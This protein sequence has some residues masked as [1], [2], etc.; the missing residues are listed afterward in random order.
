MRLALIVAMT[1]A[2]VIGRAG[3]LPWHLPSELQ[4]F[5]RTTMGKPI[6]M[7]RKTYESIGRPLPGRTNIIISRNPAFQADGCQV[8]TS[9]EAALDA[10]RKL[11]PESEAMLI[12]GAELYQQALPLANRIYLTLVEA[13][14]EG[15]TYFPKLD[16]SEWREVQRESFPADERHAYAHTRIFLERRS[17]R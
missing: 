17:T 4:F 11:T 12:G 2:G 9:L 13:E 6:I 8:F 1:P 10:A 14:L 15:D 16:S 3:S 5:K 7:G